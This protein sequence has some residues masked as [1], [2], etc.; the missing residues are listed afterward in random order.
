MIENWIDKI[1]RVF[2]IDDGKG[3]TVLSYH[4]FDKTD[5][6]ESL[7]HYPCALGYVTGC[8]PEYSE[9]IS[10][11][12]WQGLTEFHLVPNVAKS[13]MPYIVPFFGRII[14]AAAANITLGSTPGVFR[15][16]IPAE[17]NAIQFSR[18]KYGN[19]EEHFG[20]AVRWI[21]KENVD[22]TISK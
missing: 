11:L 1:A 2:E 14:R 9:T 3:G 8:R 19:E 16:S 22:L 6:P 13:N 5:L 21:V 18:L 7:E 20:I 15:F 10:L 17:D 4:S 12:Y